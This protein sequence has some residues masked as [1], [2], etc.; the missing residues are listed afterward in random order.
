MIL[1]LTQ[2]TRGIHSSVPG[3]WESSVGPV[4][5][6]Q[7]GKRLG[8]SEWDNGMLLSLC[9]IFRVRLPCYHPPKEGTVPACPSTETA[10]R[11]EKFMA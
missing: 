10:R 4:P 8:S 9:L 6:V 11:A 1:L 7:A 3:C 2:N 5:G